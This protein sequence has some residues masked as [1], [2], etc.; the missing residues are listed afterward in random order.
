VRRLLV[1]VCAVVVAD[2]MLY[3]ALVPLLPHFEHEYGLSKGGVGA[4]AASYAI[5][6][7]A[8]G[9]PGG[10]LSSRF[11]A[12]TA[13]L[14]GLVLMSLASVGLALASSYE[15]LFTARLVQG[16]GSSL[17]WAGGLSW[18]ATATPRGRRGTA[19]GTAMAAA[20]VG[21]L[22]GPVVGAIGSLVGVRW[23]FAG[24]AVLGAVLVVWALRFEA[25]PREKISLAALPRA[26]RDSGFVQ[27]LWLILLP[28][29]LF[30][31]MSVLVPLA[32]SSHGFSAVAIGAVWLG[33]A[34]IESV[35]NP[36]FGRMTDRSGFAL[37]V[38]IALLS[39]IG[40]SLALAATEWPPILVPLVL[41][42]GLAYGGYYA[43]GLALMS[44]S[45]D[46]VGIAQGLSFGVMNAAWAIGNSVGPAAGGAL[47]ELTNDSVPYL[48]MAAV[49]AATLVATRNLGRERVPVPAE[50]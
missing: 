38:R 26:F 24:I 25:A 7:L 5:G 34:A 18:L 49:C 27:G 47:A 15:A 8:G 46:D 31:V 22:L 13:V 50:T 12:R 30:G 43:P 41:V 39:S 40:M 42:S 10:L 23:V 9:I 28:A 33:S 36:L 35:I 21:A 14:G 4:L 16:F 2:T 44:N 29:L 32:L 20:I 3:A 17:T 48:V 1:L 11:G 37:P 19:M 6:T 45:A